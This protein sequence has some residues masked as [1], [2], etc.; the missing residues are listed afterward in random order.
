MSCDPD[1][2]LVPSGLLQLLHVLLCLLCTQTTP[3]L[4]H[5]Q[6]SLMYIPRH[7]HCITT[8]VDV[9]TLL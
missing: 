9:G 3:L 8:H 5:S 6:E 7:V 4:H 2:P 1:V